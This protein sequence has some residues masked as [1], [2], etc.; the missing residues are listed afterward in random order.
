MNEEKQ[1]KTYYKETFCEVHAPK[2]LAERVKNMCELKSEKK[3]GVMAKR[4]VLAAVAAVVL[5][6]G[7]NSVAY[8]TTGS[9]WIETLADTIKLYGVEYDVAL[10]E[11]QK[12]NG[13]IWYE[14][15]V[16]AENGDVAT[17]TYEQIGDT[18]YTVGVST[19]FSHSLQVTDGRAYVTDIDIK[20][21]VT[22]EVLENG[23]ATGTYEVNG[24]TKEYRVWMEGEYY[25]FEITTIYEGM[26]ED[27]WTN[28]G[29]MVEIFVTPTP[30]PT[31]EP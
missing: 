5:F 14:G 23:Q 9:T 20:I 25:H 6:A 18:I 19:E 26:E 13:E 17:V 2:A 28:T 24:Y 10:E 4:L 1:N 7:T 29:N 16:E 8:A 27:G 30:T 22:D 3:T 15:R 11:R 31:P 21:D 12:T